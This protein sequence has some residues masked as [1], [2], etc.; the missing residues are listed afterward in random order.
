[1]TRVPVPVL[2]AS[3]VLGLLTGVTAVVATSGDERP[4]V[5]SESPGVE[6]DT[7]R[8]LRAWDDRRARAYAR[9]DVSALKD[10][11]VAGS[12]TGAADVAVLRGYLG[13]HL[14]VT[15]M[16]TQLLGADVVAGGPR[17][18][19]VLVTDVLTGAVATSGHRRWALP[20][21]RPSTRRVVLVRVAGEWLVQEAY[22][23]DR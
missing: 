4:R 3:A 21:D 14:R 9:A 8:L 2:V 16:R 5:R 18:L 7:V 12:R 1:V 11:Y 20:R 13:R 6:S 19:T 17:R 15:G 22:A 23:V 10:L